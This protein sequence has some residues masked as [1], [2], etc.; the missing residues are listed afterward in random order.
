MNK[1]FKILTGLAIIAMLS[2]P[3][4]VS[5][6]DGYTGVVSLDFVQALA[7]DLVEVRVWIHNN[8]LAFSAI[9]VNLR[10]PGNVLSVQSVSFENSILIDGAYGVVNHDS[11]EH[12]LRI[13]HLPNV[14]GIIGS[15]ATNSATDGVIATIYYEVNSQASPGKYPLDSMNVKTITDGGTVFWNNINISDG[16]GTTTLL[17]GFIA[18]EV[19]VVL[20][21]AVED[22]I[23]SLPNVFGLSQNYPNPFNPMTTIE[24]NLPVAGP[25]KLQAYNILGQ[26]VAILID[27]NMS[28]G[29]HKIEFD[30]SDLPSGIYFYRI[31]HA[32][33][34][35]TR[36]MVMIK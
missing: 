10:Y 1:C 28:A 23:K 14:D 34:T 33:G 16:P 25:V 7:G 8:N 24:F 35:M 19:E 22:D 2:M 9:D 17:P 4:V 27:A 3:A 26:T 21:T 12:T 30:G 20:Q 31:S 29:N 32:A 11:T 6:Q 36:K 5:A 18:G 13:Y 15:P